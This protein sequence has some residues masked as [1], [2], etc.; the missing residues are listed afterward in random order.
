[1]FQVPVVVLTGQTESSQE[2]CKDSR[3]C[4]ESRLV[5]SETCQDSGLVLS[6]T[7]RDSRLVV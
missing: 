2:M 6:E 5:L 1:M 3:L 7:C 4:Q